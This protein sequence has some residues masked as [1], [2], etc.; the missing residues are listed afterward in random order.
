MQNFLVKSASTIFR[1]VA[2]W[3]NFGHFPSSPPLP[4][5]SKKKK[6]K[7]RE[8]KERQNPDIHG[9]TFHVQIHESG[10]EPNSVIVILTFASVVCLLPCQLKW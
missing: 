7:E 1:N 9:K 6:K 8:R 4:P 5:P 3:N 10:S 2:F